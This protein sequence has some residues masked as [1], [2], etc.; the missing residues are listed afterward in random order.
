[1]PICQGIVD[2]LFIRL[3]F[4]SVLTFFGLLGFA[5]RGSFLIPACLEYEPCSGYKATEY[6]QFKESL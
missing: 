5:N 1:M 3:Q 2:L 6:V 4:F